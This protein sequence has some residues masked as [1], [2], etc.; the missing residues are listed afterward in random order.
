M[1]IPRTF[2]DHHAFAE[3]EVQALAADA[4]AADVVA[5]TLKD[6]VKLGPRWPRIAP[7]LWYV[8]QSVHVERGEDALQHVL[9]RV[10]PTRTHPPTTP[11]R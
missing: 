4:A 8:S 10:F 2:G 1:V 6:A 7:P 5:C 3:A 9:D 11:G